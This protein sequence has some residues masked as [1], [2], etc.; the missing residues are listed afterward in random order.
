MELQVALDRLP[1][2]RAL[3][4]TGAVAPHAD[5]IEVGTSLIKQYGVAGFTAIVEAAGATP[6]LAD[7]KTADDAAFEF[8][9]FYDA[10]ASAATVLGLADD[11]TVDTAVRIAEER[12]REVVVDFMGL[13]AGRRETL[14]ARLAQTVVLAAH[15]GKDA[16]AGGARPADLLGSW[17][18]GRRLAL[19]GGLT[20]EDLPALADV[21][22]LRVI[23]G[24]A[25]T[26]ADDPLAA[27]LALGQAAHPD[28]G[29]A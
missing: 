24:S 25:V 28:G 27:V 7:L 16:Q 20:V 23:V 10:G 15:V 8:T 18:D 21:P 19:A 5:W 26:Q 22:A 12:G 29:S 3:A 13:S 2:T 11:A 9:L 1:L 6:V 14:A 4:V 17:A